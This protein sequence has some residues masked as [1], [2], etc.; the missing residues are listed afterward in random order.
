PKTGDSTN[1]TL[2]VVFALAASAGLV[3]VFIKRK[4]K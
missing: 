2:Y 4:K 3:Y 1:T